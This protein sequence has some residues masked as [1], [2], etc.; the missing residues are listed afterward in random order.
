[1]L[2]WVTALVLLVAMAG[3]VLAGTSLPM[4]ADEHEACP[5]T[6]VMDCCAKAQ[7]QPDTPEIRA[8]QLCCALN[9]SEPSP[10]TPS[11]TLNLSPQQGITLHSAPVPHAPLPAQPGLARFNLPR[12]RPPAHPAYIRHLALLI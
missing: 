7:L 12:L 8:A 6:G 10:T 11:G 5:M 4:H 3:G 9:C 1:M 2:N